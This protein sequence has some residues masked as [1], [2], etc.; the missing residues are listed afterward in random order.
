MLRSPRVCPARRTA[1]AVLL[2]AALGTVL[3]QA[4]AAAAPPA[5]DATLLDNV[6]VL[7]DGSRLS[8]GVPTG[9]VAFVLE[10]GRATGEK[11]LLVGIDEAAYADD[12][13]LLRERHRS[14][15]ERAGLG[16]AFSCFGRYS[17]EPGVTVFFDARAVRLP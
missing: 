3:A 13:S 5:P 14:Y 15:G 10:D 8:I 12:G 6:C 2:A 7:D 11:V 16:D 17:T 1:P 4:P 9:A